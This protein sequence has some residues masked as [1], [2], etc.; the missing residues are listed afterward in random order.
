[1]VGAWPRF[2]AGSGL[3]TWAGPSSPLLREIVRALRLQPDC[4]RWDSSF[5]MVLWAPEHLCASTCTSVKCGQCQPTCSGCL[6]W[7]HERGLKCIAQGHIS[8]WRV[9]KCSARLGDSSLSYSAP[10]P[11]PGSVSLSLPFLTVLRPHDSP[12][13]SPAFT[14]HSGQT[15]GQPP[16]TP[17]LPACLPPLRC[18][19]L[20]REA[21]DLMLHSDSVWL[22]FSVFPPALIL[23]GEVQGRDRPIGYKK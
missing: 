5:S 23:A 3:R 11:P 9:V 14:H 17:V 7:R 22:S 21:A 13:A 20:L 19:F 8:P 15:L 4:L 16:A 10:P 12:L 1:M 6:G 18:F 2:P